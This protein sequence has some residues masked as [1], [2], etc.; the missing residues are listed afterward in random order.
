MMQRHTLR[1]AVPT[2]G[3]MKRGRVRLAARLKHSAACLSHPHHTRAPPLLWTSAKRSLSPA[4]R[5]T[6]ECERGRE[7]EEEEEEGKGKERQR[8]RR[9][10][11]RHV[12]LS[13]RRTALSS[14]RAFFSPSLPPRGGGAAQ[15][16][17]LGPGRGAREQ[18]AESRGRRAR[19]E[20]ER[21]RPTDLHCQ[22]LSLQPSAVLHCVLARVPTLAS[23]GG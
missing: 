12:S 2:C 23:A 3:E 17:R 21:D 22:R 4:R 16:A 19:I 7:R 14:P 9:P 6:S 18:S 20:G 15:T 1:E 13:G 11:G 5:R 8:E 10:R